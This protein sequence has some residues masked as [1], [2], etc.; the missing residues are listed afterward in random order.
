MYVLRPSEVGMLLEAQK[1]LKF[2]AFTV[3]I[4]ACDGL[5]E[6]VGI[7]GMG[8]ALE[9]VEIV[10]VPGAKLVRKLKEGKTVAVAES[11]L[12]CLGKRCP[13]LRSVKCSIL[14]TKVIEWKREGDGD[15][16]VKI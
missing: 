13:N 9:V 5:A 8:V 16:W 3:A 14:R 1:G 2:L 7:L 10:G 4:E 15:E 6:I 12:V 11:Q